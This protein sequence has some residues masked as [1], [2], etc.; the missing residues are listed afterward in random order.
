MNIEKY[1]KSWYERQEEYYLSN[2]F[3]SSNK[4]ASEVLLLKSDLDKI[5]KIINGGCDIAR[6]D[7][8]SRDSY[9]LFSSFKDERLL[10]AFYL[11]SLLERDNTRYWF[12]DTLSLFNRGKNKWTNPYKIRELFLWNFLF[13]YW[14]SFPMFEYQNI[15]NFVP[16]LSAKKVHIEQEASKTELNEKWLTVSETGLPRNLVYDMIKEMSERYW[17][18]FDQ[19]GK[20]S[21][22]V[23]ANMKFVNNLMRHEDFVDSDFMNY[24]LN[25]PKF[26]KWMKE[27]LTDINEEN[28]SIY[29]IW[30]T[31][32]VIYPLFYKGTSIRS[33][34][35]LMK[36]I[37]SIMYDYEKFFAALQIVLFFLTEILNKKKLKLNEPGSFYDANKNEIETILTYC[38]YNLEESKKLIKNVVNKLKERRISVSS[39]STIT[40]NMYNDDF[41]GKVRSKNG[42][43]RKALM[44]NNT[45]TTKQNQLAERNY[46]EDFIKD[47]IK[48][49]IPKMFYEYYYTEEYLVNN[50]IS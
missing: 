37:E 21:K 39:L 26:E 24:I 48:R 28:K 40:K 47:M 16:Y 5:D 19:D 32:S 46:P 42:N 8:N 11:V 3:L 50:P 29:V 15:M 4:E 22:M 10:E 30:Y 43:K 27:R 13:L 35:P 12:S 17:F 14:E 2:D 34:Q 44:A 38:D 45:T 36:W 41:T 23:A 7:W 49:K 25:M 20:S 9:N 31:L 6:V 1:K 33:I 18:I